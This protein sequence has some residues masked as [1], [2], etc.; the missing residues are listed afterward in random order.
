[1]M[2]TL[3]YEVLILSLSGSVFFLMLIGLKPMTKKFFSPNWNYYLLCMA[4]VAFI[5]PYG[6]LVPRMQGNLVDVQSFTET[7]N[8][9]D[10][11][12]EKQQVIKNTTV[13]NIKRNLKTTAQV[14]KNSKSEN[15]PKST[16]NTNKKSFFSYVEDILVITWVLG[17]LLILSKE[18]FEVIKFSKKLKISSTDV[19]NQE[20]KE[21]FYECCRDLGIHKNIRLKVCRKIGTPMTTGI[22]RP[23]ITIPT[24]EFD[25]VTMKMIFSHEL[26]H[27]KCKDLW[28]KLISFGTLIIHW[29]NPIIY[30][31]NIELDQNCE[32]S[33]DWKVTKYMEN[34]EKKCYGITILNVMDSSISRKMILST[35]MGASTKN[36]LRERLAMIKKGK[37]QRKFIT[38]LSLAT[39]M[40]VITAGGFVTNA[41]GQKGSVKNSNDFAVMVKGSSLCAVSLSK[42]SSEVVIDKNGNFKKPS[43][44]T[45]GRYVAYTKNTGLYIA[46]TELKQ[47]TK[48]TIKIS[49]KVVSYAWGNSNDLVYSTENGGLNG[50]NLK[51]KKTS[52]YI[53]DK[54]HYEDIISD[55]NGVVYAEQYKYG[56]NADGQTI[57]PKGIISYSISPGTE[58]TIIQPKAISNDGNDMG[59]A[60][61]VAGVS[62]DRNY[63]YIWCKTRAGSLNADGVPFGIYDVKQGKLTSYGN[64]NIIALAYNDN[65]AVNPSNSKMPVVN[66]GGLRDMSSNKTIGLLNS[67]T[68]TFNSILPKGMIAMD[69]AYGTSVKG[70]STMTPAFSPDGKK[71]I[72]S[73]SKSNADTQQWIKQAHN[74]YI[75]DMSTKKVLKVTKGNTFDFAPKYISN[76]KQIVFARKTSENQIS[77]W[78]IKSN[79]QECVAKNIKIDENSAFYGHYD[80]ENSLDIYSN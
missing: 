58:K 35:S 50:Y 53:N 20:V 29:F 77:L 56:T 7:K 43:I 42:T 25:P 46:N 22:I 18:S 78:K 31:L 68:G 9:T 36:Q 21:I 45:D 59:L 28:I 1:M 30:L 24:E 19:E 12:S 8:S 51:T 38:C 16:D 3:F 61:K 48:K 5:I 76:G 72:F 70:M 67:K 60:P 2:T 74:L 13:N 55:K 79:K 6:A 11:S 65:L 54:D 63:V 64:Q 49:D 47:G 17:A 4:I 37:K 44:S 75:M 71:I 69:S 26:M 40:A 73:S 57:E 14:T 10:I 27:Y 41:F 34:E 52:N 32:L 15:I 80:L 66:I 39:A 62:K 23:T 33:C